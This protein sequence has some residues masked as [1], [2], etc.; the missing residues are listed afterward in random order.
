MNYAYSVAYS[1]H[2]ITEYTQSLSRIV[3]YTGMIQ[4]LMSE[5]MPSVSQEIVAES[6]SNFR[7]WYDLW[8][9]KLLSIL[10]SRKENKNQDMF[11]VQ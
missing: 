10:H 5:T 11:T 9:Y 1:E 8:D 7:P 2:V 3:S 4:V 6:I